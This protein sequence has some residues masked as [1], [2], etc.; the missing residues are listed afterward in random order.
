M[1]KERGYK[2]L[3]RG[4]GNLADGAAGLAGG[5]VHAVGSTA[6]GI[7]KGMANL[8]ERA[9]GRIE[10]YRSPDSGKVVEG[11]GELI[12]ELSKEIADS[13]EP[14]LKIPRGDLKK[15][16][17]LEPEKQERILERYLANHK[18][19]YV[20]IPVKTVEDTLHHLKHTKGYDPSLLEGLLQK[21]INYETPQ[22]K[23]FVQNLAH[24]VEEAKGDYI[25]ISRNELRKAAKLDPLKQEKRIKEYLA[26]GQSKYV[27][28]P[29]EELLQTL[30]HL[31]EKRGHY[32]SPLERLAYRGTALLLVM[33]AV[34]L[35]G[36]PAITGFAVSSAVWPW[37]IRVPLAMLSL[38]TAGY[39]F[40]RKR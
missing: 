36:A 4:L 31:Q 2:I 7:G 40:V 16:L 5:A 14:C 20:K 38:S 6:R 23:R 32:M 9:E 39:L 34:G 15:L 1:P 19:K 27:E 8:F 37:S 17:E 21:D 33:I 11:S 12:K 13:E 35:I 26:E 25:K 22:S 3:Y 30:G 28:I 10:G 29:R 24:Q 18:G